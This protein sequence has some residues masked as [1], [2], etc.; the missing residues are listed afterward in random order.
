[1]NIG[2]EQWE[3]LT[4]RNYSGDRVM[5]DHYCPSV[6]SLQPKHLSSDK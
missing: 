6:F 3:M 1:L 2:H 5:D 4:D